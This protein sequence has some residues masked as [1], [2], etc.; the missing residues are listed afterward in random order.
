MKT[1]KEKDMESKEKEIRLA[2]ADVLFDAQSHR[3]S[4]PDGT[5]LSGVTAMLG[6]RLFPHKYDGVPEDVLRGAA[7]RGSFVHAAC[8][9][10]DTLGVDND[11]PEAA[12][13]K[14]LRDREG[15]VHEASEYLVTDG[16]RYVSFVD[17]VYRNSASEFTLADI[18]T[19]RTLDTEYARWQLSVYALLFEGQNPGAKAA[20]LLAIWL[21]G[22]TWPGSWRSGASPT[23]TSGSSWRATRRTGSSGGRPRHA[24]TRSRCRRSTPPWRMP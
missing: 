10:I 23:A 15:L 21:R 1:G 6:R 19:T 11:A 9:M 4:L 18:K 14:A 5:P 24:G 7:A 17:K 13:Y 3:Y 12:A 2:R 8:E 22:G 16:R 20:R